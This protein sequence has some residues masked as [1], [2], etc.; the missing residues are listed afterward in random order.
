VSGAAPFALRGVAGPN[1]IAAVRRSLPAFWGSKIGQVIMAGRQDTL[2]GRDGQNRH[3][4][5][6]RALRQRTANRRRAIIS[7]RC[8]ALSGDEVPIRRSCGP[9]M[10]VCKRAAKWLQRA[11]ARRPLEVL[12]S[13]SL[14]L[15]RTP[16]VAPL[17][18]VRF[19]TISALWTD[20]LLVLITLL[21]RFARET[22]TNE[23]PRT[24]WPLSRALCR[25]RPVAYSA[26]CH[27]IVYSLL[28]T[29]VAC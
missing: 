21:V 18:V 22:V 6:Q 25:R 2:P 12:R 9:L 20:F 27:A 1:R 14:S 28:Q 17:S 13:A 19:E 11:S 29:V 15:S 26:E 8:K 3:M 23:A 4:R 16:C 7:C 24:G 5:D 10:L